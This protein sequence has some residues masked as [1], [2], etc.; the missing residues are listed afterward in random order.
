[1]GG[2]RWGRVLLGGLVAGI[3]VNVGEIVCNEVLFGERWRDAFAALGVTMTTGARAMTVWIVWG[4]LVGVTAVW[5]YAAI[6][7][8]YGAGAKTAV[9]A[10]LA[11][12]LLVSFLWSV[13][14]WNL[15]LLPGDVLAMTSAWGLVE[16]VVATLVGA[17]IYREA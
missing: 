17:W 9:C 13:G 15:G 14:L 12:W 1:M 6:R 4:L 10:G 7:P 2:I 11:V 16:L 3:I 8:R 5:L